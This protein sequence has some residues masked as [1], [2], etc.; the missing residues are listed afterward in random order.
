MHSP[1]FPGTF[2]SNFLIQICVGTLQIIYF[3]MK[4][5]GH[6]DKSN[7]WFLYLRK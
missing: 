7:F 2:P 6:F 4:D 5:S 1:T 3:N